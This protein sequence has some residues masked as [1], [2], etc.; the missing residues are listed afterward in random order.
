[1]EFLT[2][3]IVN[4]KQQ[5]IESNINTTKCKVITGISQ[6]QQSFT[7]YIYNIKQT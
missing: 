4:P 6:V 3:I 7:N 2:E 5:E 1:V